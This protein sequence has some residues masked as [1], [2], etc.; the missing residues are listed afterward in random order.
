[1]CVDSRDPWLSLLRV[2]CELAVAAASSASIMPSLN[3]ANIPLLSSS[4]QDSLAGA[5]I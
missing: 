4:H 1:M 2:G 5:L 3:S